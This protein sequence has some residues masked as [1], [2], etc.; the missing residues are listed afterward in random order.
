MRYLSTLS[1]ERKYMYSI[2]MTHC[3]IRWGICCLVIFVFIWLTSILSYLLC[4]AIFTLGKWP[5]L[6][7]WGCTPVRCHYRVK[8]VDPLSPSYTPTHSHPSPPSLSLIHSLTHSYTY[9]FFPFSFLSQQNWQSRWSIT[10]RQGHF[11]LNAISPRYSFLLEYIH[12]SLDLM[13]ARERE[14]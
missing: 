9:I 6:S 3:Q 14:R 2:I 1:W 5:S 13:W 10:Q 7:N 11:W 4:F 8:Y 12:W